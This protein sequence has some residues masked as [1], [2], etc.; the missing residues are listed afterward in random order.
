MLATLGRLGEALCVRAAEHDLH[1]EDAARPARRVRV[2]RDADAVARRVR[3][4]FDVLHRTFLG[5]PARLAPADRVA[6]FH[7]LF[8]RSLARHAAQEPLTADETGVGRRLHRARPAPRSG[9][10][11]MKRRTV[12]AAAR[13]RRRGL[14]AARCCG[15][16]PARRRRV[17]HLHPR[18]RRLGRHAVGR[19][20]QRAQRARRAGVDRQHRHR[21]RSRTGRRVALDGDTDTFEILDAGDVA[22]RFGPGDRRSLRPAR[23]PDDHQR[24]RDEHGEPPRRHRVLGDRAGTSR[25]GARRQRSIDVAIANELGTAS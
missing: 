1:G 15:P 16:L 7:A 20:A 25:A 2:R 11:L 19:P 3:G 12:L 22:M 17:L 13:R 10:L 9:A 14:A 18:G 4:R 23:S 21:P 8:G 24:P 5:Y 6:R